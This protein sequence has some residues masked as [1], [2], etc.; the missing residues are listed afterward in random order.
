MSSRLEVHAEGLMEQIRPEVVKL[1]QILDISEKA[2]QAGLNVASVIKTHVASLHISKDNVQDFVALTKEAL[3]V[4]DPV[5]LLDDDWVTYLWPA[6][7]S[8][9]FPWPILF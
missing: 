9:P 2:K 1:L 5:P 8:F 6:I 3:R 7:V 4:E